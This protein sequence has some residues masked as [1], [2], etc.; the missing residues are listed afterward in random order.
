MRYVDPRG[1][2]VTQTAHRIEAPTS[3]ESP[4]ATP[5]PP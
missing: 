2:V 5:P 1:H 4:S 3:L